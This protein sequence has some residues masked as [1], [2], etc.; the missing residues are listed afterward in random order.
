[1]SDRNG[2]DGGTGS[3]GGGLL[4]RLRGWFRSLFGGDASGTDTEA[5]A[6]GTCAVCGTRVADPEGGCPL[7]GSTDVEPHGGEEQSGADRAE[8]EEGEEPL[9]PER[10]SVPGTADDAAARLRDVRGDDADGP[11]AD[12][13]AEA[14]E[15]TG[16]GDGTPTPDGADE[17]ETAAGENSDDGRDGPTDGG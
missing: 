5:A 7:C 3:D 11:A 8:G 2:D 1:M 17:G 13:D 4:D 16:E 6:A 12:G 10:R 9:D 14:V 15:G